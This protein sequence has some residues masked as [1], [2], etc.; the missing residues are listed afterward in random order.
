MTRKDFWPTERIKQ[1]KN[2]ISRP[3]VSISTD[4]LTR[5]LVCQELLMW[6]EKILH[7]MT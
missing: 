2:M 6:H 7:V 4:L 1:L 5:Q 3:D